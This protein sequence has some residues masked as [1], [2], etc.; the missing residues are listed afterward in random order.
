[1]GDRE[2]IVASLAFRAVN[3]YAKLKFS[4]ADAYLPGPLTGAVVE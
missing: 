1:M 4:R 3:G 2:G